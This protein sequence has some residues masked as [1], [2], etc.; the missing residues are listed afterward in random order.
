MIR[1]RIATIFERLSV[2]AGPAV[3][4][5]PESPRPSWDDAPEAIS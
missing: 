5:V 4:E 1:E 2:A 3:A